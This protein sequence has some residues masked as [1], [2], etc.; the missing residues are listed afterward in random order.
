MLEIHIR[1]LVLMF[2]EGSGFSRFLMRVVFRLGLL[3]R[4]LPLDSYRASGLYQLRQVIFV[5]LQLYGRLLTFGDL[6]QILCR[7]IL[8]FP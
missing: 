7:L 4:I 3:G 5:I 1:S 8:S 6:L 2:I